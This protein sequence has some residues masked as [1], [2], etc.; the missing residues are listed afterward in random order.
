MSRNGARPALGVAVFLGLQ[1]VVIAAAV[2]WG[3]R[4]LTR[5]EAERALPALR[6]EPLAVGPL[7]DDPRVISDAELRRLLARLPLAGA[8]GAPA[9]PI[10]QVDHSLRLWGRRP[11]FDDPEQLPSWEMQ[12]RLLD[13]QHFSLVYRGAQAP[14]LL[15]DRDADSGDAG[16]RV[17]VGVDDASASHVDHTLAT[18]GEIG[19]PLSSPVRTALRETTLRS[20][21][22]GSLRSFSLHQA[23]VEWSALAYALYLPP[24]KRWL[25][26]EGEEVSFDRLAERLMRARAGAGA[27]SANHRLHAL[28]TFLR[29]DDQM[30][31]AGEGGILAPGARRRIVD[32]LADT[33]AAFVRHQHAQGFWNF[34]WP[35]AAR[36][37][38]EPTERDGDRL[39]DRII[40]TGHVL[41]WWALAPEELQPPRSV[42]HAAARWLIDVIDRLAPAEI[43]RYNSFLSHAGRALALWRAK[44]PAEVD[45]A[46]TATTRHATRGGSSPG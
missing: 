43:Q 42:V 10:A 27:C 32:F 16:V 34:D 31:E 12:R 29:V 23:E 5:L 36:A 4:L 30:A 9:A 20:L 38:L 18:L 33:T 11:P 35:S 22:E 6:A 41:E 13:H 15:D 25:S 8:R 45:L 28:V 37:A 2:A 19:M 26:S 1:M 40:A 14:L 3:A 24:A 46:V 21:L 7:Y 44:L 17:R 39:S